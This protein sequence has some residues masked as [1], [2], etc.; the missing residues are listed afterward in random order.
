MVLRLSVGV[1][2]VNAVFFGSG[3]CNPIPRL[4][5]CDAEIWLTLRVLQLCMHAGFNQFDVV[6]TRTRR[7]NLISDG[8][9]PDIPDNF[10]KAA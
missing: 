5:C 7:P 3:E 8:D 1:V 10:E 9:I 4:T 6:F 2:T